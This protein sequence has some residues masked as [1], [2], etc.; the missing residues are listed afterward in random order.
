MILYDILSII[1]IGISH[2]VFYFQL[3]RY[4][5]LSYP[6][7]IIISIIFTILLG[8]VVTMTGYPE[9]NVIMY[10]IF[11]LSLGLMQSKLSFTHNL[12][13]TLAS[14]V[15]ITLIK[16]TLVE[17]GMHFLLWSPFNLYIW[18]ASM[19][20]FIVSLIILSCIVLLRK[21]IQQFAS[22]VI[23]GY[24]YYISFI[25]LVFGL[26][27]VLILTNPTSSFLANL[28]QQYSRVGYTAVFVLFFILLLIVLIGFHLTKDRL[29]E[30]QQE[31]LDRAL[32]DYVNKLEVMHDELANFRHDYINLL[33]TL[34]EGIRKE[35]INQ[36]KQIYHDVIA[37]TSELISHHELDII[38]LSHVY[39]HEIKSVLSAKVIDAQQKS[40]HVMID[41]PKPIEKIAMPMVNFIRIISILIDNAVEEAIKTEEKSLQIAF[42]EQEDKQYFII[43]NSTR[44]EKINLEQIYQKDY[45]SKEMHDGYGLYSLKHIIDKATNVTLETSL[46]DFLFTQTVTIKR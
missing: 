10:L 18:S 32:L 45:S 4:R 9:F 36:V 12:Y 43:R 13:F 27:L 22:F 1:L 6:M 19:I 29:I 11:L 37:P 21:P 38:K 20:H 14:M 23:E 2:V 35:D 15:S 30:E 16:V 26:F 46:N 40:L 24:M 44:Q 39:I 28:H 34:D 33:L 17:L 7:K 31:E 25:L 5:Q 3:I 41:I 8:I 42:F